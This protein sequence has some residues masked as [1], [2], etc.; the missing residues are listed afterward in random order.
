M[1]SLKLMLPFLLTLVINDCLAQD[2]MAVNLKK[3]N[4]PV[5][6]TI[7]YLSDDSREVSL[8]N[9]TSGN[10]PIQISIWY[11]SAKGEK[12]IKNQG[13]FAHYDNGLMIQFPDKT[14][15][16]AN[17]E[18]FKKRFI[19][20]GSSEERLAQFLNTET[21][22]YL[23]AEPDGKKHPLLLYAP[24]FNSRPHENIKL[25]EYL[26]SHGFIVVSS[27]CVGPKSRKMEMSAAGAEAQMKDIL[28]LLNY[29]LKNHSDQIDKKR[30]AAIGFSWG[31]A[32]AALAQMKD[33]R[34]KAVVDIDGALRT[35]RMFEAISGSEFYNIDKATVPYVFYESKLPLPKHWE[36]LPDDNFTH[37]NKM[38]AEKYHLKFLKLRHIKFMNLNVDLF[39][40]NPDMNETDQA[41]IVD[42]YHHM[43]RHLLQFLEVHLTKQSKNKAAL[44]ESKNPN[45]YSARG[46]N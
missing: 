1:H 8:E 40:P 44:E 18:Y 5:G 32:A 19:N 29:M 42:S 21:G 7:K 9:N 30:I 22:T 20:W 35:P 23:Q 25:A 2:H 6:F 15:Q 13:Y 10:R 27:P 45:L 43:A 46:S 34:I 31:G 37:Y 39:P 36:D 26:A 11:P 33:K 28:F 38:K 14:L 12:K 16:N 4:F 24:S 17:I 41:L 3:G